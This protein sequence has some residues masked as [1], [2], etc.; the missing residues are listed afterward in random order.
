MYQMFIS[1]IKQLNN[2]AKLRPLQLPEQKIFEVVIE[3]L[4]YEKQKNSPDYFLR[5]L[6]EFINENRIVM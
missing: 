3:C 6:Q 4:R 1:T 5:K 2:L